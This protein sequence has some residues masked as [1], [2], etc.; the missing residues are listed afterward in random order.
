MLTKELGTVFMTFINIEILN[1]SGNYRKQYNVAQIIRNG[2]H[3]IIHKIR[4]TIQ[5]IIRNGNY[6]II[7]KI[8][9]TI[10]CCT[11]N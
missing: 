5:Q 9:Q 11:N 4:K 2:I 8:R 3:A 1:K 7:Y 6:A 10:Q